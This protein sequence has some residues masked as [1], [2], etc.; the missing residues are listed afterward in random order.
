MSRK[1]I[2]AFNVKIKGDS[3]LVMVFFVSGPLNLSLRVRR[4]NL[5]GFYNLDCFIGRYDRLAIKMYILM[6]NRDASMN[7]E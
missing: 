3:D 2:S 6:I 1:N 4:S 5:P 7:R